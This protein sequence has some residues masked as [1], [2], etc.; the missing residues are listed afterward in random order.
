MSKA[1][2]RVLPDPAHALPT[3]AIRFCAEYPEPRM[4]RQPERL[5]DSYDVVIIGGGG[6]GL[7]AAYYLAHDYGITDVAVLEKGYIGGGNTGRQHGHRP[8]ELPHGRGGAS[9]TTRACGCLQELSQ[10]LDLNLFYSERGHFTLAHTDGD[11][12]DDAVAGRGEQAPG[13]QQRR[14]HARGDPQDL[15]V[16]RPDL[17]RAQRRSSARCIIRRARSS[18]TT[19]SPGATPARPIAAAW[20]STRRPPSPASRSR[21]ARSS[22]CRPTAASSRRS[23]VLSAVAG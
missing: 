2:G 12:A 6:H 7:A 14:R 8:L 15:P 13:R 10:D 19:R 20:R 22:A 23:K 18:G 3:A 5:K 21:T 9:S 17:R 1:A 16:H 4:F 11:A